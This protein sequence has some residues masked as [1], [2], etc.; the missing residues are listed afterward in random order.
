VNSSPAFKWLVIVLVPLTLGWKVVGQERTSSEAKVDIIEFLSRHGFEVTKRAWGDVSL[1]DATAATT[2]VCRMSVVEVSPDGWTR[3]IAHQIFGETEHQFFVFRGSTYT[4]QPTWLTFSD[5]LWSRSLR[6]LGFAR[7][8][9]PVI[10]VS[11]TGPCGAERLPWDE[12]SSRT[13]NVPL[14]IPGPLRMEN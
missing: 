1:I 9:A 11:A 3:D 14:L 4:K 5:H 2:G 8:D 13:S 10:A 12:L 7:S 6:K